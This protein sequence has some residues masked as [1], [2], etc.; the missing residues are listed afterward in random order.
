MFS[1]CLFSSKRASLL[2]AGREEEKGGEDDAGLKGSASSAH[3]PAPAA[4]F[5]FST[6]G[7]ERLFGRQSELD[8]PSGDAEH[9]GD[10]RKSTLNVC[11]TRRPGYFVTPVG[12]MTLLFLIRQLRMSR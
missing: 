6:Q 11:R 7:S 10:I 3:Q 9:G 4:G 5:C 2:P 12:L 8:F 1:G